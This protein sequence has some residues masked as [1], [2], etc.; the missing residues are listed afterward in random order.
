M[1]NFMS[2][3][4]KCADS[5]QDNVSVTENGAIGLKTT[6]KALLDL[7]FMLS[8]M[9]NMPED[10]IYDRFLLAYNENPA[11][12]L[13]WLFFARDCRGGCGERRTFRAI[14]K[15][16][17]CENESVAIRLLPLIPD[18]GRWDDL[19]DI[20]FADVPLSV[21]DE[22]FQILHKQIQNDIMR[23]NHD[24]SIS[25]LAKWIPSS[26]S[27]S[28]ESRQRAEVLRNVFGWTPKQYRKNLSGL[29][30]H[31]DVTER[32]MSAG[33][34]SEINYESVPSRA[35]MNYRG[36]F[37]RHDAER[38]A[39][40]LTNVKDGKAKIHSG[41]LFP[42][43]IV[44]AYFKDGRIHGVNATLEEQWKALPNKV[45]VNGSTLVVVDGSGSMCS[46]I[47][48]TKVSC[49]DV[50]RSLGVYFAEKLSGPYYNS[51]ITF[52]ANPRFVHFADG[53][54]LN[55]KLK[56]LENYDECS[57]TNIEKTFDLILD[58]AVNNHLKQEE[59]PA[60]VLI[61]SDM[62][63]DAATYRCGWFWQSADEGAVNRALFDTIAERFA[64]RGYKLPRLVFWNVCSRTGTVPV[65]TNELGVALVSGFS[66][67]VADMV[68]SG[69]IDPYK[70]LVDK[71]MSDRYKPVLNALKE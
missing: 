19:I 5:M 69:D 6:G 7:N 37:E 3:L 13:V 58:T 55:A 21:R 14:F 16:F 35:A 40:Y 61:V 15:R 49:H 70:C 10:E 24:L 33:E 17:A 38:Y 29:R 42:Y 57:N 36:A 9:R 34:W 54:T 30:K 27:S 1:D 45:P 56:I 31:L 47:S 4:K 68:M 59:L 71:L 44:H 11:L 18:F 48:G 28:R 32:K 62:E 8:S 20:A 60:N 64:A 2:E 25:V 53:L 23:C 41:A 43:D 65:S 26:N 12:A 63:F 67:N 51:F 22:S 52:S 46:Y 66:P 39:D 50:A